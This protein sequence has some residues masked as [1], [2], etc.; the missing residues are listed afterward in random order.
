MAERGQIITAASL[1]ADGAFKFQLLDG[2]VLDT[3]KS[4]IYRNAPD[5]RGHVEIGYLDE[6]SEELIVGEIWAQKIEDV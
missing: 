2:V 5:L 1:S 6:L 4:A 3:K